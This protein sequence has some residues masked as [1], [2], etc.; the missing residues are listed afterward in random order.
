MSGAVTISTGRGAPG[1]TEGGDDPWS[2]LQA[3]LEAWSR[4]GLAARF[5]WRDDDATRPGP[6]LDCLLETAGSTP[7][8]LAV[9][10]ATAQESLAERLAAHN[11]GGG[12]AMVLQH[13]YAHLDHA[14]PG[15]KK[16]EFGD[17]RPL[18]L[19]LDELARGRQRMEALFGAIFEP[20][21]TPPWNRVGNSL[22][23]D[24][25]RSGLQGLSRYG[26]RG[27]NEGDRVVNTHIDIV[28][29][30]RGRGFVG[31]RQALDAAVR[32]LAARRA[33]KA[34]MGEPTGLLTH[35]RDHDEDCWRFIAAFRAAVDGHP[36][37]EWASP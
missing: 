35:H 8:A 1:T 20:F 27:V 24:L 16:A 30:R 22:V 17:H 3:E 28:D 37:A 7:I 18:D 23:G 34:D 10:P 19:M 11:A 13:G 31:E 29:W 26:P 21:L 9:V 12:D 33:G 36:A 5:W 4:A 32:H 14:P 15:E 2:D 25:H 6:K